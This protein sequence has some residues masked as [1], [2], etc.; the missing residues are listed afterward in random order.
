MPPR[1]RVLAGPSYDSLSPLPLNTDST[2]SSTAF[3]LKTP[4]FEGRIVGNIKGFVDDAGEVVPSKY[5]QREDRR[6]DGVTWS[7]Q[8]QGRFLEPVSANDVMFGNTFDRPLKLP[9]GTAA[10]LQFA[11]YID[12]V[13]TEDL[14]GSQPWAL[15]PAISTMPHITSMRHPKNSPLPSFNP[16]E[17]FVTEDIRPLLSGTTTPPSP[18]GLTT[19]SKRKKYFE[20][21]SR[22]KAVT[23]G[24]DVILHMDFCYGYFQFPELVLA[25]PGGITFDLKKYWDKQPVRFVC[26][27]R[28]EEGKGPGQT[29]F[30]VQFEVP[31][32]EEGEKPEPAADV[33]E[34]R[35]QTDEDKNLAEDID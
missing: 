28:G 13:L 32:Y 30:V 26:C 9:W 5:F 33:E 8:I 22:R 15:S 23:Y 1:F 4:H 34:G 31:E 35:E 21:E 18:P 14:T 2:D 10:A 6:K 24:P 12:P 27:R 29:F 16:L 17:P 19:A 25:I 3:S 11:H 20:K 7:I